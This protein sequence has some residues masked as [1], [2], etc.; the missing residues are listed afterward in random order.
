VGENDILLRI[1]R[2]THRLRS[3]ATNVSALIRGRLYAGLITPCPMPPEAMLWL[4]CLFRTSGICGTYVTFNWDNVFEKY[5]GDRYQA[6]LVIQS[7]KRR[8]VQRHV[9]LSKPPIECFH[10]HGY[11][12]L[13]DVEA[14]ELP[15]VFDLISYVEEYAGFINSLSATLLNVMANHH[16]IFFGLHMADANLLRLI[17]MAHE[18]RGNNPH[19]VW[20]IAFGTISF[21]LTTA[22]ESW[23]I[24]APD[25]F[26]TYRDPEEF[27][28]IPQAVLEC[29]GFEPGNLTRIAWA[30]ESER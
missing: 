20:G 26:R 18:M 5:V 21:E 12:P 7:P 17:K 3:E 28:R 22:L 1:F 14:T 23:G 6:P 16:C 24:Q 13:D 19:D 2:I 10:L 30:F 11:M 27:S 9:P 8:V 4:E 29:L 15:L 25:E